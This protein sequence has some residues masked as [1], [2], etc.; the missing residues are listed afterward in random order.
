MYRCQITGKVSKP[1]EKLNKVVAQTRP[2]V[3]TKWVRDEETT[4][5]IEVEGGRGFEIVKELS[6]SNAGLE[7]WNGWTAEQ[8]NAWLKRA[9]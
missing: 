8:K 3:Y 7:L 1:G 4:H 6:L 2:R 5:W 9:A